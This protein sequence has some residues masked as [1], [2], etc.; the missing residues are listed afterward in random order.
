MYTHF[1]FTVFTVDSLSAFQ[2]AKTSFWK[3]GQ[4]MQLTFV[5]ISKIEPV[6]A[7]LFLPPS[8]ASPSPVL[9][10]WLFLKRN[11]IFLVHTFLFLIFYNKINH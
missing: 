3:L 11:F 10:K 1:V 7:L 8:L 5:G 4:K 2:F 6:A 9:I